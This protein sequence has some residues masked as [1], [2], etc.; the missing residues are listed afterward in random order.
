MDLC[1][2]R[3][4]SRLSAASRESSLTRTSHRS[5]APAHTRR[6]RSQSADRPPVLNRQRSLSRDRERWSS[7]GGGE[8]GRPFM[9]ATASSRERVARSTSRDRSFNSVASSSR[10]RSSSPALH[11]KS[12]RSRLSVAVV[13]VFIVSYS[14]QL[15]GNVWLNWE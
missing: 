8:R 7:G 3:D 2:T 5:A 13:S 15:S 9:R 12:T 10:Q 4:N 14:M 11:C 1:L 6:D